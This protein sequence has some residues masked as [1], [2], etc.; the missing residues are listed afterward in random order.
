MRQA[1]AILFLAH[2]LDNA[3]AEFIARN[4]L[5]LFTTSP[6]QTKI[7]RRT[8]IFASRTSSTGSCE[9]KVRAD[10]RPLGKTF[11]RKGTGDINKM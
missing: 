3:T 11:C 5:H 10:R 4:R 8:A 6:S 7:F 9:A 1:N 2:L